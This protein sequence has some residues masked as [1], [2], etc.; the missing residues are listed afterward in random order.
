MHDENAAPF[1]Q[2]PHCFCQIPLTDLKKWAYEKFVQ[3]KTTAEL[4]AMA[5]SDYECE[6]A[7][8]VALLDVDSQTL[9]RVLC[10]RTRPN[11]NLEKCRTMVREW[12]IAMAAM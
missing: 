9:N 2:D 6:L 8:V 1:T 12:L 3:K 5:Q 11:C 10:H 4:L 7:T